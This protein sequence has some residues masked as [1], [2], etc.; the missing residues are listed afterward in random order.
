MVVIWKKILTMVVAGSIDM[1]NRISSL[2]A[3]LAKYYGDSITVTVHQFLVAGGLV[4]GV[5]RLCRSVLQPDPEMSRSQLATDALGFA[6]CVESSDIRI[7]QI[8]QAG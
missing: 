5:S 3:G 4:C 8:E 1:S 2:L 6:Q 7:E